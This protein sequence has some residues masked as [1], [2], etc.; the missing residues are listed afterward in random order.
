MYRLQLIGV[1]GTD[2][3][4][5]EVGTRKAINFRVAV[6]KDYK[7][8]SGKKVEKTEWIQ[9][10]IWKSESQN[11]KV[12]EYLKKG[13]KVLVEGEPTVDAFIAKDGTASG[14]INLN[15]KEVEFLN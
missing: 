13:K 6:N 12:A 2:A 15:V 14:S 8:S 7:D 3:E 4:V 11:T 5:R 10:V 1:L 9:A